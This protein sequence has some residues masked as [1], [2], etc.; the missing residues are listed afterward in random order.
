M[1][2]L[3]CTYFFFHHLTIQ[4]PHYAHDTPS[5][6]RARNTTSPE[7]EGAVHNP[8]TWVDSLKCN[9][10][11]WRKPVYERVLHAATG[12]SS[13]PSKDRRNQRLSTNTA[14][15]TAVSFPSVSL[16]SHTQL[17]LLTLYRYR[18]TYSY[19]THLRHAHPLHAHPPPHH[20][21][22]TPLGRE[23]KTRDIPSLG[24][25]G[26]VLNFATAHGSLPAANGLMIHFH[27]MSS[28]L[29]GNGLQPPSSI[30]D[31]PSVLACCTTIRLSSQH[32]LGY[33]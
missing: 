14:T 2:P 3:I 25:E 26:A 18:L 20:I 31:V 33:A 1:L 30:L 21:F 4:I 23:G 17:Y 27:P 32:R 22:T 29:D 16:S 13:L 19:Y 11:K 8:A 9:G 28:K 5:D 6:V 12:V 7:R 15:D 10:R 24:R